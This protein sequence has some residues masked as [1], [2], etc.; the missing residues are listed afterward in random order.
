MHNSWRQDS[1]HDQALVLRF[2]RRTKVR[3]LERALT[4]AASEGTDMGA[5]VNSEDQKRSGS[6]SADRGCSI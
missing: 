6:A 3:E 5:K 1:Q 2:Q 4:L